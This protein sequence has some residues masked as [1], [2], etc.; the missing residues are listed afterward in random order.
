MALKFISIA[1]LLRARGDGGVRGD[2]G[3]I[4][5]AHAGVV[6]PLTPKRAPPPPAASGDQ[7]ERLNGR[8][9]IEPQ[10]PCEFQAT[11]PSDPTDPTKFEGVAPP[12]SSDDIGTPIN[13]DTRFDTW[14]VL[15]LAQ[16][17]C[18]FKTATNSDE[19]YPRLEVVPGDIPTQAPTGGHIEPPVVPA[20][21][22]AWQALADAYH[23]HHFC[24]LT[25]IAAGRGLMY[26]ERCAPGMFL[27]TAYD[28]Q[29]IAGGERVTLDLY[30]N[31]LPLQECHDK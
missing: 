8:G 17:G 24:C 5:N 21:P 19:F 4:A 9:G 2:N 16:G 7:G 15:D 26:W 22:I 3:C 28:E 25:C 27:W 23:A 6:V 18:E 12:S 29:F 11:A 14:H 10:H 13:T 30:S 1:D 20:D 31:P